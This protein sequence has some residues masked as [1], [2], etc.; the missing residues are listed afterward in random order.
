MLKS[1]VKMIQL[2]SQ[3]TS[4]TVELNRLSVHQDF[5]GL[6][7]GK[8]LVAKLIEIAKYNGYTTMYL[9]TSDPQVAG[10]RLYEKLG[11]EYLHSLPMMVYGIHIG[12]LCGL[13]DVA[14]IKRLQ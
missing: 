7:I 3:M 2:Y 4:D 9:D 10:Q 1:I 12:L 13:K 11:F 6:K 8:K 14:F 5:R